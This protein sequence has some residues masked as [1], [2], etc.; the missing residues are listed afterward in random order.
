MIIDV[1]DKSASVSVGCDVYANYR[2]HIGAKFWVE[3]GDNCLFGSDCLIIDHNHGR[4]IGD[5]QSYPSENPV[6]RILTGGGIKI[7]SNCW[8]GD[9]V[10]VLPGV[11][12]GSGVVVG[13][14]AVVTHDLPSDVI[15][16][17][18]PAKV[19]KRFDHDSGVWKDENDVD[20]AS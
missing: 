19:I 1:L 14:G 3:I 2:L 5:F 8:F 15:A 6:D 13:V 20:H 4:Y 18:A 9:R 11:T 12:I 10:T 7:G 16:V 17:G